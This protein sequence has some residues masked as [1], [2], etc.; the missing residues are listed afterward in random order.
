MHIRPKVRLRDHAGGSRAR[1]EWADWHISILIEKRWGGS[2]GIWYIPEFTE[3]GGELS[4]I[5]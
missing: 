3:I 2:E 4:A 1:P 5:L